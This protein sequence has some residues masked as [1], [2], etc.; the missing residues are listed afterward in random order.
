MFYHHYSRKHLSQ[1]S[2]HYAGQLTSLCWLPFND[3]TYISLQNSRCLCSNI[4]SFYHCRNYFILV[5]VGVEFFPGSLGRRR[6]YT[7]DGQDM[8]SPNLDLLPSL[9][10]QWFPLGEPFN[11]QRKTQLTFNHLKNPCV[12][13][14]ASKTCFLFCPINV[15]R[16]S[17]VLWKKCHCPQVPGVMFCWCWNQTRFASQEL[18]VLAWKQVIWFQIRQQRLDKTIFPMTCPDF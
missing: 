3:C 16:F 11:V 7:L 8:N 6:E 14:V 10:V 12:L 2:S 1:W 5:I 17:Y 9:A 13:Q 18:S 15:I 4:R